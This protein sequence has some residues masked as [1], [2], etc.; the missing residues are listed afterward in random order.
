MPGST[1][2]IGEIHYGAQLEELPEMTLYRVSGLSTYTHML[3][4]GDDF[5]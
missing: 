3:R 4:D 1:D 2:D 5:L